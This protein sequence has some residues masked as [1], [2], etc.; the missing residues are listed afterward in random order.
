MYATP[1]PPS[2]SQSALQGLLR[3]V[4]MIAGAALNSSIGAYLEVTSSYR[5]TCDGHSMGLPAYSSTG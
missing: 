4:P 5:L 1:S 3:A 2:L